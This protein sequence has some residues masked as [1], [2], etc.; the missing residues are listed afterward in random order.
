MR[1]TAPLAAALMALL[2]AA[3][4]VRAEPDAAPAAGPDGTL[5][6]ARCA[7]CH[8]KTGAG[9]PGAF[10][11]LGPDVRTMAA[12]DTGRRYLALVVTR[13]ISGPIKVGGK[14]YGGVMPA[15]GALDDASVAAVLNHVGTVIVK[16]GPAFQPFSAA[17]ITTLRARGTA[18][19]AQ[20]VGK[21]R[22]AAGGQ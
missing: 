11:P 6:Y 2:A 1:N 18:L 9:V 19:S 12:I 14:P 10:P 21:L 15:Q 4:P 20:D 8:T 17:E 13:G 22:A 3:L 5:I 16:D 7:A